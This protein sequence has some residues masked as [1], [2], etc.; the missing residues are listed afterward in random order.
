MKDRKHGEVINTTH[1]LFLDYVNDFISVA[2]FA[3]YHN[4]PEKS[5]LHI[6]TKGRALHNSQFG[7]IL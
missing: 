6:I 3:A 1:A 7:P 4:I 5:A 2:G